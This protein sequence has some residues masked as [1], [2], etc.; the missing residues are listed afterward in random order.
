MIKNFTALC[1]VLLLFEGYAKADFE[2]AAGRV[3]KVTA[4][5]EKS[6][7]VSE[8]HHRVKNN[9]AIILSILDLQQDQLVLLL[10]S[11]FSLLHH[12]FPLNS[13]IIS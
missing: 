7:L 13:E 2:F 8:L 6:L 1:A 5:A 9:M 10:G 3:E 11:Y 4:L 12:N